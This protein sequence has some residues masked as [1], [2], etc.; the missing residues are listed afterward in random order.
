MARLKREK[1]KL[2]QEEMLELQKLLTTRSVPIGKARRAQIILLY[3]DGKRIVDILR[4]LGGNRPLI[5][6][7]INKALR[8][9]ALAALDDL[10][11]PGRPNLITDD[12]VA[13]VL[14]LACQSPGNFDYAAES[15]TYS[16]LIRH[17]RGNCG[18]AGFPCLSNVGKSLLNKILAKSNVKPH[19]ISYYLEKRD[20]DFDAK[21][22]TVL[23]VYQEVNADMEN[24][25]PRHKATVSYDEKPGIQALKNIAPQLGPVPGK[26]QAIGRDYEYKRLGTVT[27]LA[28]LDLHT[29]KVISLVRERHCSKEFTEFLDL[30]DREYDP[31]WKLRVIL[32][33]HSA[34]TSKETQKYLAAKPNRFE[35]VFTPKHGSWLNMIEMFFSKAS[36]SFLRHIRVNSKAEL[37]ER[38]YRGI[39]EMNAEPVIFRWKYK[40]EEMRTM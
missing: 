6:R 7:T 20:P 34:H 9:G 27:L 2:D 35:F 8:F 29:G 13:W 37:T 30:L 22:A 4:E 24:E 10:P 19:K 36:R 3:A 28:G 5:E 38:I 25:S 26:Y 14:N 1:L 12:A 15:W 23:C 17:I 21:M 18:E 40:M 31:A 16:A 11:R 32:D 39:E 33:N